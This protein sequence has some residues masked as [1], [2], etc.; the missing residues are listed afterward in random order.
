MNVE[1][2]SMS[3]PLFNGRI[4]Y[5][6]WFGKFFFSFSFLLSLAFFNSKH[7][8]TFFSLK[9]QIIESIFQLLNTNLEYM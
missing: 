2:E 3:L 6:S 5:F 9:F 8:A 7:Y 1:N 4:L